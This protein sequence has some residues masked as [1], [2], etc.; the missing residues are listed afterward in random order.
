MPQTH[1]IE[2]VNQLLR[3]ELSDLLLRE[4]KDPRLSGYISINSV[5]TTPDLRYARVLVSCLCDEEKKKEILAALSHSAGF[6]RSE[7]AK[8]LKMRRVPEFSFFWDTS[9]ER[10][11]NLLSYMDKV[12]GEQ[13]EKGNKS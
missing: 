7:L 6:F 10:G 3:Q 9:I 13:D 1:R 8:H 2:K 12:L 11:A 5:T 4:T